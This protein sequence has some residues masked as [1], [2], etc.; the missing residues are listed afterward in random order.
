MAVVA[1]VAVGVVAAAA[2][3]VQTSL[4]ACVGCN[5]VGDLASALRDDHAAV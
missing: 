4:T 2:V 1:V 3:P 5:Q